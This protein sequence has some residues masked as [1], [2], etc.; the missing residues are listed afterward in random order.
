MTTATTTT[1]LKMRPGWVTWSFRPSTSPCPT[2]STP[3]TS[4]PPPCPCSTTHPTH[5]WQSQQKANKYLSGRLR[6]C[7]LTVPHLHFTLLQTCRYR[8]AYWQMRLHPNQLSGC[9]QKSHPSTRC[10][11]PSCQVQNCML[12]T[13]GFQFSPPFP[14][15]FFQ[16]K[17]K[18]KSNTF[19]IFFSRFFCSAKNS[20]ASRALML[21]L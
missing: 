16:N 14:S 9:T 10:C 11:S 4:P 15:M 8:Y 17:K 7:A 13:F 20:W 2:H 1:T 21:L 3:H 12:C 18:R 6:R 19:S 5:R